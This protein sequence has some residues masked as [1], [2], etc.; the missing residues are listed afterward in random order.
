MCASYMRIPQV[1][2]LRDN[3]DREDETVS[4]AKAALEEERKKSAASEARLHTYIAYN[5][6]NA[7][8]HVCL[9]ACM[10]VCMYVC[11][12]VVKLFDNAE[13]R[14]YTL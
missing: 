10:H 1:S 14:T 5:Y 8:L 7:C 11:M 3:L 13:N 2:E 9:H 12:Y 4:A 6:M